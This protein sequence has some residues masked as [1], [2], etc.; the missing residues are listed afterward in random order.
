MR[1]TTKY[2]EW[3]KR[4]LITLEVSEKWEST[5]AKI[6]PNLFYSLSYKIS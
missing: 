6:K 2:F 1:H 4:N 5:I 3:L